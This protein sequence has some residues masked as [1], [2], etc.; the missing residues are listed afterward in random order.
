MKIILAGHTFL[1]SAAMNI[2]LWFYLTPTPHT[3]PFQLLALF[4][5]LIQIR[6]LFR[7]KSG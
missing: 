5:K 4:S 3:T 6:A 7:E 2:W 1:L